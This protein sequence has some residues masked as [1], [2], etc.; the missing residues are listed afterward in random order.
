LL[1]NSIYAAIGPYEG[2]RGMSWQGFASH[3][4]AAM[5]IEARFSITLLV[6]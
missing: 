1:K 4:T 6:R 5:S 2:N 3:L